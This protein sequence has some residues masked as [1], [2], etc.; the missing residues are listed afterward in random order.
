MDFPVRVRPLEAGDRAF[1]LNSWLKSNRDG[2]MVRRIPNTVYYDRHHSLV[3][4]LLAT[5]N[6]LVICDPDSPSVVY[7]Y[8]CFDITAGNEFVLH[9][10]YTK[11]SFRRMGLMRA[12]L[13]DLD[14]TE[15]PS[16]YVATHNTS[17]VSEEWIQKRGIDYD[18]YRLFAAREVIYEDR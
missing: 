2:F 11:Q 6:T 17:H 1:V 16:R 12:L 15:K 7:G 10:A 14:E 18:P 13:K 9:Y 3:G 4:H 8:V 5:A